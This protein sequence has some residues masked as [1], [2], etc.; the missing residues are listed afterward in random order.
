MSV[1]LDMGVSSSL[2]FGSIPK[3]KRYRLMVRLRESNHQVILAETSPLRSYALSDLVF[4]IQLCIHT[5]APPFFM[6]PRGTTGASA[7]LA[8]NCILAIYW[9]SGTQVRPT[10]VTSS[11]TSRVRRPSSFYD[12]GVPNTFIPLS[13]PVSVLVRN[14]LPFQ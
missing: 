3:T 1:V 12:D 6:N 9:R 8:A 2:P 5:L 14:D 13:R 11:T 4:D 7:S 10:Y